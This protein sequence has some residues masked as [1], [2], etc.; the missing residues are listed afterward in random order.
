MQ[1]NEIKAGAILSYG[2]I[3]LTTITGMFYTP[4]MLRQLGQ[5]EY[6]LYMLIGSFVGYISI[7][8]FGLHNTIYRFIA[9]YQAEKDNENQESFLA[10]CFIIY[11]I[12]TI[13]VLVVGV[14]LFLNLESIFSKSLTSSELYKAKI[15]FV[16]LIIN[17]ALSLP[18]GA[19]QFILR[20]YG[21]FIF[22]N[23]VSI[24]RIILRTLVLIGLLSLG[25]KSI[26]IV[27]I[28]TIFNIAMGLTYLIYCFYKLRVKIKVH[29]LNKYFF[30]D[31]LSYSLFIFILAMV[32]Q[33]FWKIGHVT[34]GIIAN[35]AAVAVY[36]LSINLVMY[37][38]NIALS[39][40]GV[41]MP[42]VTDLIANGATGEDL[43]DLMVK[44][45][46]V[47]LSILGLVLTGFIILGKQFI[48]LWAGSEYSQVYWITVLLFISSTIAMIQTTGGV[49][50][51][52]SNMISFKAKAYLIMSVLNV[53]LSFF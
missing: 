19:F 48:F 10:A 25:Y 6:G 50:L 26:A 43:T 24:A 23:S 1:N 31:I 5:S 47:Q 8:D 28:D 51:Q 41:L 21:K 38:Q 7:L 18:M 9:K 22:A 40:S 20:G 35:T 12:I 13:L 2:I 30:K 16:V 49:I 14:I 34:L 36:A 42:K 4:F 17:L 11:G 44:V 53:F 45:G 29:V 52:A 39:I 3:V 15:M 33:I 46:R 32:N 27:I 37:Y